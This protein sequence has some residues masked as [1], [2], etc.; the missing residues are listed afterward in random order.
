MEGSDDDLEAR[1]EDVHPEISESLRLRL[2][3]WCNRLLG[4]MLKDFE[5]R[6]WTPR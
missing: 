1:F 3:N 2:M 6:S 5:E 4:R